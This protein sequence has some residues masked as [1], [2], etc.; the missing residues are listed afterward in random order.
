MDDK[1]D[2]ELALEFDNHKARVAAIK[3]QAHHW[4]LVDADGQS[5]NRMRSALLS[6]MSELE[7]SL[8][9]A[10][11]HFVQYV[12]AG[13]PLEATKTVEQLDQLAKRWEVMN[14]HLQ[15]VNNAVLERQLHLRMVRLLGSEQRVW[16]WDLTIFIS[17]LLVVGLVIFEMLFNPPPNVITTIIYID[18]TFA[19]IFLADFFLRLYLSENNRWY[20]RNYWIDFVSSLPFVGP[21]RFGRLLRLARLMR[22]LRLRKAVAFLRR[23]FRSLDKLIETFQLNLLKRAIYIA[24]I[25]LIFGAISINRLEGTTGP[26]INNFGNSLWWSFTTVVTGG[27][28]DLY[29]PGTGW[30]R[31]ITVSLILL[32]LVVTGIFTASLTSVLIG[33]DSSRIEQNQHLLE[34]NISFVNQKLDQLSDKSN[35]GLIALETV[36]QTVSNQRSLSQ[37]MESI[38]NSLIKDFEAR[39]ASIHLLDRQQG[40]LV[41]LINVGPEEMSPPERIPLDS[42]FLGQL[43]RELDVP[44][45]ADRDLEPEVE[46]YAPAAAMRMACPMVAQRRLIGFLHV[47]LPGETGRL[48]LYN[49]APMTLAHHAAMAI[50]LLQNGSHS[51]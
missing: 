6:E 9:T 22:L 17:I 16:F 18:T 43:A 48:Y 42:G 28:A 14:A 34:Q 29:N 30:G 8:E 41:R 49:R 3:R 35:S 20:I 36:A 13:R 51:K 24:A 21:A 4:R 11:Q 2:L 47:V 38:A 5:L 1:R 12:E 44:D 33:D 40:E 19:V 7:D 23:T 25:L 32:G 46:L 39:Q 50:V 26:G 37:L 31:L 27:F 10:N 45:V 15:D